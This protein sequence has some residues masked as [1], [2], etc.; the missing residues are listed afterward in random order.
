MHHTT[1]LLEEARAKVSFPLPEMTKLLYGNDDRQY[2]LVKG[3]QDVLDTYPEM[4]NDADYFN[5]GRKT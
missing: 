1:A 4:A 2:Q 5:Q 3:T